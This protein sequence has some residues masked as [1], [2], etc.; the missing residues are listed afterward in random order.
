MTTA[1]I[2]SPSVSAGLAFKNSKA[3]ML[4]EKPALTL[5]L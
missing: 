2:G 3:L 1:G 5:G 4:I